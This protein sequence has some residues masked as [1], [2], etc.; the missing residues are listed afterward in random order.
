MPFTLVHSDVWGPSQNPICDGMRWFVTFID[1]CT[2]ITW[3]YLLKHK[4][5]VSHAIKQFCMMIQTQ[6][7]TNIKVLHSDNGGEYVNHDLAEFF[8]SQGM[9]HQTSYPYT[10]QQNGVV[11]RRNRQFWKLPEHF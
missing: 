7:A 8:L 4:S 1:D 2:R 10:P 9:I 11:E 6:F 3:I 5:D